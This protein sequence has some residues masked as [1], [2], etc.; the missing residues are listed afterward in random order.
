MAAPAS[1]APLI[2]GYWT[3]QAIYVA[4]KLGLSD[5]LA[6]G[7]QTAEQLAGATGTHAESLFRPAAGAGQRG[8]VPAAGPTGKF[9]LTPAAELLRGDVPGSQRALA[10]MIGEEHYAAWGE[11]MYSIRTGENAFKRCSAS[12]VRLA[13]RA[14]RT[15]GRVRPGDGQCPWR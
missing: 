11:L 7:P 1:L 15:S 2:T 3:S 12:R 8:R 14:S 13:E 10:I 6:G 4:A 9:A 5:Q